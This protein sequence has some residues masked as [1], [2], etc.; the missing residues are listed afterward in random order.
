MGNILSVNVTDRRKN[1]MHK[2]CGSRFREIL[3]LGYTIE[4]F[5]TS[6][7]FH[8]LKDGNGRKDEN[9]R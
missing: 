2:K 7:I 5:A 6:A 1:L 9:G 3:R 4:Q 8:D